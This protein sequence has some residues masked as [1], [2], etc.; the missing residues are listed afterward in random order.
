M[1]IEGMRL[2]RNNMLNVYVLGKEEI[3]IIFP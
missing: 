2:Y 1:M 3:D